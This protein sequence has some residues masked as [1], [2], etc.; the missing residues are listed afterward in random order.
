MH[1]AVIISLFLRHEKSLDVQTSSIWDSRIHEMSVPILR[2]RLNA[3]IS[4]I[5]RRVAFA[6][7][8]QPVDVKLDESGYVTAQV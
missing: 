8:E 5:S 7:G 1:S 6:S 2:Y 3:Q 4:C